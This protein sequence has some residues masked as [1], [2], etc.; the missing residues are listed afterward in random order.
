MQVSTWEKESFYAPADII[1]AGA[2]FVG[3]WSA[4]YLKKKQPDLRITVIDRGAIPTGASTRNA[5]FACFGS[6]TELMSDV[7]T[8]GEDKMLQLVEMRYKG[9]KRIR[10]VFGKKEIDYAKCGGYEIIPSV[11]PDRYKELQW[12][13][14]WLNR[15]LA[16]VTQTRSTFTFADNAIQKFGFTG[17]EHIIYNDLEGSLH[18]GKLCQGLLQQVQAMKVNVLTATTIDHFEETS[19]NVIVHTNKKVGANEGISTTSN[20][21]ITASKL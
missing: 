7:A 2:G 18:P 5:G 11:T 21:S 8:L 3:L 20:I 12:Q 10:K 6:V 19:S 16:P 9:L 17:I 13:V 1:I 15:L 4:Y 14:K